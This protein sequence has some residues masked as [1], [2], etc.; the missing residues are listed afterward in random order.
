MPSVNK[1]KLNICATDYV[2]TTDE[3]DSYMRELAGE[4]D[5]DMR[6]LLDSDPRISTTMAAVMTALTNADRARKAEAAADN[7]RSQMKGYL[8][9]NAKARQEAENARREADAL[10]RELDQL[11]GQTRL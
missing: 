3:S 8:D 2:L 10:R 4:V 9:D 7:L 6:V 11:S 5:H 1:I